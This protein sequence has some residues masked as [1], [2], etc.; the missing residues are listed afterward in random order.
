LVDIFGMGGNGCEVRS[1]M[2]WSPGQHGS[3]SATE[4][5]GVDC[6]TWIAVM[7]IH[8]LLLGFEVG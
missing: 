1:G 8:T 5:V 4:L 6:F 3:T 7:Y 2:K